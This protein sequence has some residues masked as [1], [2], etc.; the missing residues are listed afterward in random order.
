MKYNMGCGFNKLD[1]YVNV[2]KYSQCFPDLQVD[3]E[4]LPWPIQSDCAS[5]VL[6]NHSLEH[7]GHEPEVFLGIIKE[8]YRISQP[9]AQII[10]NVPHPRHDYFIGD[11][12]HVRPITP[13][14]LSLFSKTNNHAWI[15]AGMPNTPLA[16]YLDVD[17]EMMGLEE[18]LDPRYSVDFNAGHLS[19]LDIQRLA[20][21]RN[22]VIQDYRFTLRTIK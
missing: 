19:A 15:D 10:I 17:F 8:I 1:G 11:P 7:L 5:E 2:D 4:D 18:V 22:N 14:V 20:M 6:F 13:L 12:T 21:E 3:L 9:N 16:L